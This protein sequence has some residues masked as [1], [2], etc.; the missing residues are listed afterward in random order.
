MIYRRFIKRILDF[1]ISL[2]TLIIFSP[3]FIVVAVLVKVKL[4]VRC[5]SVRKGRVRMK[6]YLQFTSSEQ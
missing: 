1:T 4:E 3:I 2:I 6:R 5:F